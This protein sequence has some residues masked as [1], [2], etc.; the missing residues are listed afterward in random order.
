M[1]ET[2]SIQAKLGFDSRPRRLRPKNAFELG[3]LTDLMV[4]YKRANVKIFRNMLLINSGI[5][6]TVKMAIMRM[7]V[8][9]DRGTDMVI[10]IFKMMNIIMM[11]FSRR[12][13][14]II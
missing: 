2:I 13:N 11:N 4:G 8:S 3:P 6:D 5:R 1:P 12:M 10:M 9:K 14:T 7:K